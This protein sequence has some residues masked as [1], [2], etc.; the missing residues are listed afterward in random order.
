M[1]YSIVSDWD[2]LIDSLPA[3]RKDVYFTKSYVSLYE[4]DENPAMCVVCRDAEKILLLPFLR[5]EID[6]YYDFET[7]YGYG[8]PVTNA[9]AELKK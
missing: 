4:S 6:G 2:E 8:G 9:D 5:G 1:D 7:A 3:D